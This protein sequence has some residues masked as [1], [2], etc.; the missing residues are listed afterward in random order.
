MNFLPKQN[1]FMAYG[2]HGSIFQHCGYQTGQYGRTNRGRQVV[3]SGQNL[4]H[5]VFEWPL[6]VL[7]HKLFEITTLSRTLNCPTDPNQG[8]DEMTLTGTGDSLRRGVGSLLGNLQK[9]KLTFAGMQQN[10]SDARQITSRQ[11]RKDSPTA[12]TLFYLEPLH[13]SYILLF[14]FA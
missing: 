14:A 11:F 13:T 3:K 8:V 2:N 9:L 12:Y 1:Q 7:F 4:V 10:L 5:L 6:N